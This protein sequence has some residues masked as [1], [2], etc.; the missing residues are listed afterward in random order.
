MAMPR[1]KTKIKATRPMPEGVAKGRGEGERDP[2]TGRF[3]GKA[4]L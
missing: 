2:R 4:D 3:M 1:K